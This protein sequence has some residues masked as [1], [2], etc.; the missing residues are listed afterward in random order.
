MG[1]VLV[2][3]EGAHAQCAD[4]AG[5]VVTWCDGA[6]LDGVGADEA[7]LGVVGVGVVGIVGFRFGL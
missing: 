3:V 7:D 6:V 5:D 1:A 4:V 2:L